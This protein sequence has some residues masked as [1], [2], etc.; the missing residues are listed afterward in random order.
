MIHIGRAAAVALILACAAVV[1][2]QPRAFTLEDLV[3][4]VR[5]LVTQPA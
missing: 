3:A 5:D 1:G 4:Q 2:A